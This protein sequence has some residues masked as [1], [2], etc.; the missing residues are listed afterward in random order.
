MAIKNQLIYVSPINEIKQEQDILTLLK[1][2][3]LNLDKFSCNIKKTEVIKLIE[4]GKYQQKSD[5]I[6]YTEIDLSHAKKLLD[7]YKHLS[8]RGCKSCRN[9]ISFKPTSSETCF[10]CQIGETQESIPDITRRSRSPKIRKNYG[11]GCIDRVPI[12]KPLEEILYSF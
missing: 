11:V 1:D 9:N 12:F 3:Q 4:Q 5:V 10:Y 6:F 7:D 8:E 2:V